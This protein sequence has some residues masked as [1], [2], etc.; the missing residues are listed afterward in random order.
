MENN[1]L[2]FL[3]Q[4]VKY[5]N[6]LFSGIG[7]GIILY[8]IPFFFA[9]KSKNTEALAT[10]SSEAKTPLTFTIL[11]IIALFIITCSFVINRLRKKN[12]YNKLFFNIF[13]VLLALSIPNIISLLWK[14]DTEDTFFT[15]KCSYLKFLDVLDYTALP[16]ALLILHCLEDIFNPRNYHYSAE[17][18]SYIMYIIFRFTIGIMYLWFSILCCVMLYKS[19]F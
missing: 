18:H 6:T 8:L 1:K 13:N 19:F 17:P 9:S 16:I 14:W 2:L 7:F 10:I 3:S 12:V 4:L 15:T 5:K 11:F